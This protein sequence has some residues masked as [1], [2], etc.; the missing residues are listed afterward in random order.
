[1]KKIIVII[2]FIASMFILTACSD[3][4]DN[5]QQDPTTYHT[6]SG[7]GEYCVIEDHKASQGQG[8]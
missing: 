1:M 2:G 7:F 4:Q 6:N 3:K 5:Q 8:E